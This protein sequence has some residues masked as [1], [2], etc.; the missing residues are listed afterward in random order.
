MPSLFRD[1]YLGPTKE[2]IEDE[3]L[4]TAN[5]IAKTMRPGDKVE[6]TRQDNG[7]LFVLATLRMDN[8]RQT[9]EN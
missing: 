2:E 4:D 1:V 6:I 3:L 7:N 8:A 9:Q 5:R